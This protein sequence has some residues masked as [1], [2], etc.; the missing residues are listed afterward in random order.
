MAVPLVPVGPDVPD[1][2][3]SILKSHQEAI[4]ALQSPGAPTPLFSIDTAANLLTQAPAASFPNCFAQVVDKSSIAHSVLVTG[5]WTWLRAD[6]T[7]L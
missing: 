2:V 4:L 7:S 1:S 6:G 5:T 3:A